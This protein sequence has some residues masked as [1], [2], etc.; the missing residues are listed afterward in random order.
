[1]YNFPEVQVEYLGYQKFAEGMNKFCLGETHCEKNSVRRTQRRRVARFPDVNGLSIAENKASQQI[2]YNE[3]HST[4]RCTTSSTKIVLLCSEINTSHGR[5]RPLCS[6][7]PLVEN[8]QLLEQTYYFRIFK[9]G[10][11]VRSK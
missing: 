8:V 2:R 5:F 3:C 9:F 7:G 10:G 4:D 1:M 11:Y 6:R